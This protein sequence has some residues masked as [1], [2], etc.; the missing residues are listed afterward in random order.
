MSRGGVECKIKC[1]GID[2]TEVLK[3]KSSDRELS[4][5]LSLTLVEVAAQ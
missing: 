5:Q 1:V 2:P 3:I 4:V